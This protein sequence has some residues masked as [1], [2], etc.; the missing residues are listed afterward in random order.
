M[1]TPT[2][3]PTLERCSVKDWR[4]VGRI[5]VEEKEMTEKKRKILEGS[6]F[7]EEGVLLD[8]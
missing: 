1:G 8:S 3:C 6:Q 2:L 4:V 7:Q 5:D